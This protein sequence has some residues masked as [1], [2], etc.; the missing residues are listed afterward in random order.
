MNNAVVLDPP[1]LLPADCQL[2]DGVLANF[3]DEARIVQW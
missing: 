3:E 1:T 2:R